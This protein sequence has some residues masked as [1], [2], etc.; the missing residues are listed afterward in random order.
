[1]VDVRWTQGLADLD[2]CE[3][4]ARGLHGPHLHT[5]DHR[6]AGNLVVED[7]RIE[8]EHDFLTGLRVAQNRD[9]VAHRAGAA[10]ASGFFPQALGGHPLQALAGRILLPSVVTDL[11]ARHG[12]AHLRR[13]TRQRVGA[14]VD[15]VVH[16]DSLCARSR[17][18]ARRPHSVYPYSADRRRSS[19]L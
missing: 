6:R 16:G 4:S 5:A 15:D 3:E 8:I 17:A 11:A 7:V 13:G 10:E 1:D 18:L 2:R 9:E 19:S 14:E 12:L